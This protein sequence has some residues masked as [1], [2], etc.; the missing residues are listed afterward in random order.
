[1]LFFVK[2]PNHDK[3]PFTLNQLLLIYSIASA[4]NIKYAAKKLFIAQSTL[5]TQ[6]KNLETELN[7]LLFYRKR[8]RSKLTYNGQ[9]FMRYVSRIL[10]LC[11][12]GEYVICNASLKKKANTNRFNSNNWDTYYTSISAEFSNI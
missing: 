7:S 6:I 12:E 1:M 10:A 2:V 5:S 11:Y 8:M 3:F 9:I 4:G